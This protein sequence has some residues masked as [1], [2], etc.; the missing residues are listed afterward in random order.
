MYNIF[1]WCAKKVEVVLAVQ[2]NYVRSQC[3]WEALTKDGK[4]VIRLIEGAKD[5][6]VSVRDQTKSLLMHDTVFYC[7][8]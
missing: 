2:G 5:Q 4:G 6:P 1:K 7:V 3:T 8:I